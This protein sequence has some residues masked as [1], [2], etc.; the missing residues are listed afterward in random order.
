MNVEFV[1]PECDTRCTFSQETLAS[2]PRC[3]KCHHPLPVGMEYLPTMTATVIGDSSSSTTSPD[4]SRAHP[5]TV[6]RFQVRDHLGSGAFGA[7]YRAYDPLLDREVALKVPHAGLMQ[8]SAEVA[9][10]LREPKAAAQLRHPHIVPIFEVSALPEGL[11]LASAFIE[12]E[13]LQARLKQGRLPL[14]QA[15]SLVMRLAEALHY[16]HTKGIVHRDVKPANV[17]LDQSEEPMLMDFGLARMIESTDQLTHAGTIMGTPAYMPP[18]QARGDIARVGPASDQYAV[19]VTLYECL[20]GVRPFSGP[21]SVVLARVQQEEPPLLSSRGVSVPRDLE[22][23]C[24][25]AMSKEPERRYATCHELAEDL[26]R[27]LDDEPIRARP[28]GLVERLTRWCRRNPAIAGLSVTV[29]LVFLV[30]LLTTLWQWKNAEKQTVIA[31]QKATEAEASERVAKEKEQLALALEAETRQ[32]RDN[33]TIALA[34]ARRNLYVAHMNWVQSAWE[35]GREELCQSLLAYYDPPKHLP[36]ADTSEPIV[37]TEDLRHFEWYYLNRLCR[38]PLSDITVY[39]AAS[40]VSFGPDGQTIVTANQSTLLSVW[41]LPEGKHLRDLKGHTA[42]VT[43]IQFQP[44]SHRVASSAKDR[45]IRLW[46]SVT[47]DL[48]QTLGPVPHE[49]QGFCWSPD[50]KKV[51]SISL[52]EW[53]LWEAETGELLASFPQ[54]GQAIA[55]HP[56]GTSLVTSKGNALLLLDLQT[57]EERQRF[58]ASMPTKIVDVAVSPDGRWIGAGVSNQVLIWD[59]TSGELH[60]TQTIPS[61][62]VAS[63]AFSPDSQRVAVGS[64]DRTIRVWNTVSNHLEFKFHWDFAFPCRVAWSRDGQRLAGTAGSIVRVWEVPRQPAERVVE[65]GLLQPPLAALTST[66]NCVAFSHDGQWLASSL[67]KNSITLR[68]AVTR[69][70]VRTLEGHTAP[71]QTIA[72]TPDRQHLVSSG[73]D[74]AIMLWDVKTG[75]L[76]RQFGPCS[77]EVLRIACN[78]QGTQIATGSQDHAIQIW[79][80]ANGE[81]LNTLRGSANAVCDVAFHPDGTQLVSCDHTRVRVWNTETGKER[82]NLEGGVMNHGCARFS[83]DGK[84]LAIADRLNIKLCDAHTGLL[85]QTLS[86]HT[87]YVKTLLYSL[88]GQRVLSA[89][90][91][92]TIKVWGTNPAATLLTLTGHRHA[93]NSLA[94]SPSQDQLASLSVDNALFLWSGTPLAPTISPP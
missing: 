30:G 65:S 50:G 60:V 90:M 66:A 53:R 62:V 84:E 80:L 69:D 18:E 87:G 59:T 75:Q 79:N 21:P 13:T 85:K 78:A 58:S 12:G 64:S 22:T 28:L 92:H 11:C 52:A 17:M 72:F 20:C 70:T 6:G 36:P 29:I 83:P 76:V 91:D 2:S 44:G 93:I 14:R 16:A 49:V 54:G 45:T 15:A 7:V 42:A 37:A 38:A 3:R 63:L 10:A 88:D 34:G 8:S 41:S 23:I 9:R 57:G 32:E 89:S 71:V 67:G 31:S 55:F 39:G 27:W 48:L 82:L 81:L 74:R 56:D 47:G 24:R 4:N 1:C 19:G 35:D 5:D 73:K 77:G 68:N 26:R 46:D 25:K 94:F 40:S 43:Q 61:T 86:G 33:V 51:A